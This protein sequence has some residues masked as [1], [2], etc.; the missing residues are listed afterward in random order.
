MEG[1]SWSFDKQLIILQEVVGLGK[2]NE[3]EFRL[4]PF[5][6][7]LYNLPIA[8]MNKETWLFLGGLIGEVKEIDKG[9]S[10]DCLGKF[11]RVRVLVDVLK[12]LKRIV[13]VTAGKSRKIVTNMICYE[14]LP[15]LCYFCIRI[16][17]LIKDCPENNKG[18]ID[19]SEL[20]FGPW[21]RALMVDLNKTKTGSETIKKN[22]DIEPVVENALIVVNMEDATDIDYMD[23]EDTVNYIMANGGMVSTETVELKK[24]GGQTEIPIRL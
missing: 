3:P 11:I 22:S 19:D 5:W 6:V 17:H 4:V 10:G 21:M 13:R 7:Q 24:Q 9:S 2:V 23:D 15:N 16:G 14:R 1:G 20:G 12:P 8:F 18:L